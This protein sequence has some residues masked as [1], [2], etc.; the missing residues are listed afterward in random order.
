MQ[1]YPQPQLATI[2]LPHYIPEDGDLFFE[3]IQEYLSPEDQLRV[4]E[5]FEVA[6]EEHGTDHRVSGELYFTHP[7]T[8]AYYLARHR[9]DAPTLMAALLH[10]VAEDTRITVPQIQ[11]MFGSEVSR[12]V[13]GVTKLKNV[14]NGQVT[15]ASLHK[16][17][18]HT[19]QD[20]RVVLVKIFDRLHNMRTIHHLPVNKQR[21]KARETIEVYAPM[22]N[23]LGMWQIKSEL[24][25]HSLK[26]LNPRA[27]ENISRR[28]QDLEAEHRLIAPQ[29]IEQIIETLE[30]ASVLV[31]NAEYY[32]RQVYSVFHDLQI[33][34]GGFDEIDHSM[35]MV[36]LVEDEL[37]CYTA[38]GCLHQLWPPV[39]LRFD[40]YIAVPRDN[41]Y[42]SLHTTLVH[43]SGQ[44]L[45]LR[46]RTVP[47]DNV[48]RIG[49][50]ARWEYGASKAWG[51][52]VSNRVDTFLENLREEVER[53]PDNVGYTVQGVVDNLL[54]D[55]IRL[56]TPKGEMKELRKGATPVDFAYTIHT[57]VGHQ[58]QS[59]LI[60]GVQ[61]PLNY[62]LHDGDQVHI[63]KRLDA[64]PQRIWLDEDLGYIVTNRAKSKVR[65]WFRRLP[66]REVIGEGR[67]LL[68]EELEMLG[69]PHYEHVD[70]ARA[71]GFYNAKDLYWAL[72]VATMLPTD[73][74]TKV[75]ELTWS[76]WPTKR[77][78]NMVM[79]EKGEMYVITHAEGLD[80]ELCMVC[81][82]EP[83]DRIMGVL[84]ETEYVTVHRAACRLLT[85][86]EQERHLMKLGWG[87]QSPAQAR[88]VTI[89]VDVHDRVGILHDITNL[90][91][92]EEINI[93]YLAVPRQDRTKQMIF[94]LEILSPRDLVRVLHRIM[95][96]VNVYSVQCL[97]ENLPNIP[98]STPSNEENIYLPPE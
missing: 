81:N 69:C 64:R 78:G 98:H 42:R 90:L 67:K 17:F 88:V 91:M 37:S 77:V 97:P 20:V 29:T 13:D 57:E 12:L 32:P 48:S 36:V 6:R 59:A 52:K 54:G 95:A 45:K 50:L 96:L 70:I 9:L 7:L 18:Q 31:I 79:A 38:L 60:N 93:T 11:Q 15:E 30:T 82:P 5:A 39:A 74:A 68:Q 4:R 24:E 49:V 58:C 75:A 26:A 14:S 61:V 83:G 44:H 47:M 21:N 16:L 41:L 51:L 33:S 72:G 66:D 92:Q 23:R 73:L 1:Q 76:V 94:E 22:A 43:N 85:E 80:I 40:D 27:H 63:E 71:L 2:D 25:A 55:Q 10:D 62:Q 35:R 56:Y 28:L 86:R 34:G 87:E 8:V 89:N 53:E 84:E 65:R 46:I 3:R 19:A